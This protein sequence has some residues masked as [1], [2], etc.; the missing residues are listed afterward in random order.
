MQLSFDAADRLVELVE[1]RH[2]PVP[3][4]DAARTLY[5]LRHVPAGLA[6][7]LLADVVEGDARLSW[8]GANV[9]LADEP[10]TELLLESAVYVVV[11]LETTGLSP[12]SSIGSARSARSVC[13]ALELEERFETL[14]NP[15]RAA[16]GRD[17]RTHRDRPAR[18]AWRTAG[19]ELAV[20]RFLEF[21]G[22][23]VLVAHNA[24]FD[25][26]FLDREVERLTGRRIAGPVVDTVWL[27]RRAARRP[28]R[29]ASGSRRSRTS[30]ARRRDRATGHS[31]DA[32]ATAEILLGADRSRTGAWR[33][34]SRRAG[35]P[36]GASRAQAGGQALARRGS[37]AATGGL[38]LPRPERAGALRRDAP[39]T[40]ARGSARTSRTERQRPAVE[41]ALGALERVEWRVLGS[42]LEACARGAATPARAAAAGECPQHP[43]RSPRVPAP[44][45]S[46]LVRHG[47]AW[48]A[49]ATQESRASASRRSGA[50][51]VEGEPA[52]AL[53]P[54]RAKLK[55][56]SGD[57]RFEDAARLRDRIAALAEV[58][59]TPLS[60]IGFAPSSSA[61]SCRRLKTVFSARSSSRAGA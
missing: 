38:P 8:R 1:A 61:C 24:R 25:I 19:P 30:S 9:G 39:A 4:E 49:R 40:S 32:E 54:L 36:R 42:E 55:R 2:G 17:R 34:H 29:S 33:K 5:S 21:A 58:A 46:R 14:V 50:R 45:R 52:D 47:H 15:R 6:R 27:A 48:S 10:G 7:S 26:G 41:A 44:A 28:G 35:R 13:A 51:R 53:P 59:G 23:A 12:G 57:L 20:R 37:A 56:L 3:A 22:D 31:H 60:W 43:A 18:A 16:A 11:D